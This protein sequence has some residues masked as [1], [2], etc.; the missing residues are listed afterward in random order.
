M[1]KS[2]KQSLVLPTYMCLLQI[3]CYPTAIYPTKCQSCH[4]SCSNA[5]GSDR[6][7][8]WWCPLSAH[9]G[10]GYQDI[11]RWFGEKYAPKTISE[12]HISKIINV[13]RPWALSRSVPTQPS[14]IQPI[15][16]NLQKAEQLDAALYLE[17]RNI[18]TMQGMARKTQHQTS[19]TGFFRACTDLS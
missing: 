1:L 16:F 2:S 15:H 13:E 19:I 14:K 11:E 12:S 8:T 3:N 6:K 5:P 18:K 9:A 17:K 10:Y 7:R 4:P